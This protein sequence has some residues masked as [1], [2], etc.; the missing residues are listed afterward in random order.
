MSNVTDIN[1]SNDA[2]KVATIITASLFGLVGILP[3]S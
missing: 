3:S 1:T 2:S